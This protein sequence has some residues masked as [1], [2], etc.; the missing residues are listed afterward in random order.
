MPDNKN[1]VVPVLHP[2]SGDVHS[3]EVPHDL[4]VS[5]FHSALEDYYSE[6]KP[7]REGSVEFSPAFQQ[8]TAKAWQDSGS[9]SNPLAESGFS[10][11]RNGAV[12]PIQ[13][14]HSM[15]GQIPTDKI[16]L[17]SPNDLGVVHT[18]PDRFDSKPSDVDIKAAKTLKK[19]V[20]VA[21]KFGLYS[22]SP[23]GSVTHIYDS[24][25][26]AGKK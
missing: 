18:H 22:V 16:Q 12:G 2:D 15:F 19:T 5:Q 6:S 7:S 4:P 26:K 23:D 17:S 9:G 11:A 3:I 24:I 13:T 21:S 10:V 1:I 8:Q 20:W 25:P 14:N